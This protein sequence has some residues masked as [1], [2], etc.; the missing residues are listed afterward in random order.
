[1]TKE[2]DADRFAESLEDILNRVNSNAQQELPQA[3]RKGV[4]AG[5]REWRKGARSLFTGTYVKHGETRQ[6]GA[7]AKSIRSH[8]LKADGAV[9]SGE[10]GSPKMPG[11]AH[12]LE[13]GHARVG[14]GR[15][16][17][18]PHVADA[19]DKAFEVT[20]REVEEAVGRAIDDA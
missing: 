4:L 5:A 3:I 12:L 10:V 19:A 13:F 17:A 15:V 20:E 16:R 14:G 11:L 8:M 6:A 1:M 2:I 9:V 7:Y 18:Y